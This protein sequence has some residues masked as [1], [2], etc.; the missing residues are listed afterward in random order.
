M[1]P[2]APEGIFDVDKADNMEVSETTTSRRALLK[3]A[4]AAGVA[5]AVYAA[6][7]VNSVPAYATHGLSSYTFTSSTLCFGFSPNHQDTRGDYHIAGL[8]AP[9]NAGTDKPTLVADG[10]TLTDSNYPVGGIG[11]S[12]DHNPDCRSWVNLTTRNQIKVKYTLNGKVR[13]LTI[14][15]NI[16]AL[17]A[18]KKK[19][20][21]AGYTGGGMSIR[22]D[23]AL[24][25]IQ[26]FGLRA[27]DITPGPLDCEESNYSLTDV[28]SHTSPIDSALKPA[29]WKPFDTWYQ[30]G[31]TV[32]YHSGA[33]WGSRI[34]GFNF[35]IRC[36]D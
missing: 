23:D 31:Q 18:D 11:S 2:I 35:R 29:G 9:G 8:S 3:G 20:A 12:F 13:T 5:G 33:I 32:Y 27:D 7:M 24:C 14:G 1:E 25:E 19:A 17:G 34:K 28:I 16:H 15:G 21:S 22:L 10:G 36:N 26:F 4:V 6:P 30:G